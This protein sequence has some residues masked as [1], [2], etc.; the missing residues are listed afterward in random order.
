MT[1]LGAGKRRLG[2]STCGQLVRAVDVDRQ[3]AP[4]SADICTDHLVFFVSMFSASLT[5]PPLFSTSH[6]EWVRSR[7]QGSDLTVMPFVA[8]P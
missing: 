8:G 2:P 1:A 3:A 4:K 7:A 6:V 5:L